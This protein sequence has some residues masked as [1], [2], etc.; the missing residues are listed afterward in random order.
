MPPGQAH[1]KVTVE[2]IVRQEH[3]QGNLEVEDAVIYILQG[4]QSKDNLF[5]KQKE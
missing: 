4:G 2:E 1:V 3:Y 5:V